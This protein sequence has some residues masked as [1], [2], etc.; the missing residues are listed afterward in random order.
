LCDPLLIFIRELVEAKQATREEVADI[1]GKVKA[2]IAAAV[3]SAVASPYP[4]PED[5]AKDYFA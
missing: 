5:A 4:P 3:N 1:E 2:E